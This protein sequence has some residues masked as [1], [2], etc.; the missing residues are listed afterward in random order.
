MHTIAN[1]PDL[2]SSRKALARSLSISEFQ[3]RPRLEKQPSVTSVLSR[4]STGRMAPS[5]RG[6]TKTSSHEIP[7]TRVAPLRTASGSLRRIRRRPPVQ[8][9]VQKDG[10]GTQVTRSMKKGP[11][12]PKQPTKQNIQKVLNSP[13][14]RKSLQ[15]GSPVLVKKQLVL[16]ADGTKVLRKTS[17]VLSP[18][19][20]SVARSVSSAAAAA[21]APRMDGIAPK[22]RKERHAAPPS[23]SQAW[24]SKILNDNPERIST[25]SQTPPSSLRA[26]RK[27][28]QP[29]SLHD[30][31]SDVREVGGDGTKKAAASSKHHQGGLNIAKMEAANRRAM[32]EYGSPHTVASAPVLPSQN[33][34]R[35][36]S[37]QFES[38]PKETKEPW[39]G[40]IKSE[41]QSVSKE[42]QPV[43]KNELS[44][45]SLPREARPS[46]QLDKQNEK[47]K[48]QE[49]PKER[50]KGAPRRVQK[51]AVNPKRQYPNGPVTSN[52]QGTDEKSR[53]RRKPA[54]RPTVRN[55]DEKSRSRRIIMSE[56]ARAR[57]TGSSD[58]PSKG[59]PPPNNN[60]D[61][62][63]KE[64]P[65]PARANAATRTNNISPAKKATAAKV[66]KTTKEDIPQR[67]MTE[68]E[69]Q[70]SPSHQLRPKKPAPPPAINQ[71]LRES[72][73]DAELSPSQLRPKQPV[74][75]ATSQALQSEVELSLSQLRPKKQV[76]PSASQ[77]WRGKLLEDESGHEEANDDDQ[78]K[79][80]QAMHASAPELGAARGEESHIITRPDGTR[81]KRTL[82]RRTSAS[83]SVETDPVRN[84]HKTVEI[85][86]KPDG[87]KVRR[88]T[89]RTPRAP[90][91]PAVVS[92]PPSPT[93]RIVSPRIVKKKV[94]RPGEPK[95]EEET[96]AAPVSKI[97]SLID[98]AMDSHLATTTGEE[99]RQAAGPGSPETSPK[100]GN[101]SVRGKQ[102]AGAPTK[103]TRKQVDPPVG[104]IGMDDAGSDVDDDLT[105]GS[106]GDSKTKLDYYAVER[107]RSWVNNKP[108][109]VQP[110]EGTKLKKKKKPKGEIIT[111]PDG[112]RVR[113]VKKVI[114]K[115]AIKDHHKMTETELIEQISKHD[116]AISVAL[117]NLDGATVVSRPKSPMMGDRST[118]SSKT[119]IHTP[120]T[121]N[122][123]SQ[124]IAPQ[125][126]PKASNVSQINVKTEVCQPPP[127]Q[128]RKRELP[129]QSGATKVVPIRKP[130]PQPATT[131]RSQPKVD[132]VINPRTGQPMRRVRKQERNVSTS[133]TKPAP[134]D[135]E[136]QQSKPEIVTQPDG[137]RVKR[138]RKVR[139]RHNVVQGPEPKTEVAAEQ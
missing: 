6:V 51:R 33:M 89:Q 59:G 139:H 61:Q 35:A 18:K 105:M 39:Q 9:L 13:K 71:V 98:M 107:A 12:S 80:I 111:K 16:K 10:G 109:Q 123:R 112:T 122:V 22:V 88:I 121:S 21:V 132:V 84:T 28:V 34:V 78:A 66:A 31:K 37:Q 127:P 82:V 42:L 20:K 2:R 119:P 90:P 3:Q 120:K 94:V 137:T 85:V 108:K 5:V 55:A 91:V 19:K 49:T 26:E 96:T 53:S 115:S 72:K 76:P 74:P 101:S 32:L 93:K 7:R 97:K 138:I 73:A 63:P 92:P 62:K 116:G 136:W 75:P 47:P 125:P 135:E 124:R 106:F 30:K 86:T 58:V 14:L 1:L 17:I 95:K 117:A 25:T 114:P 77:A 48:H 36:L 41:K 68:S 87:T 27:F 118:S 134:V 130:V 11:Q 102:T 43:S 129:N 65:T 104:E 54:T 44:T 8:R 70:Q 100:P 50:P 46:T 113:R 38:R 57:P 103:E 133:K 69:E 40:E 45:T 83:S 131:Q 24:R 79:F 52:A 81:V 60:N 126:T 64:P 4:Q 56:N 128:F 67:S 99:I 23:S 15:S 29:V 110:K